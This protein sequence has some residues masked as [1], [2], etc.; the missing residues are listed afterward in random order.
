MKEVV[1]PETLHLLFTVCAIS[2]PLVDPGLTPERSSSFDVI[3]VAYPGQTQVTWPQFH[4]SA[5]RQIL[6]LRSPFS[7]YCA[8]AEFLR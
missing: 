4:G 7:A 3:V 2:F 6:R 8:S 1:R 5:Y